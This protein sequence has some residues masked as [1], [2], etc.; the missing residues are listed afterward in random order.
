MDRIDEHWYTPDGALNIEKNYARL[1]EAPYDIENV[2]LGNE[3]W[4]G[5]REGRALLAFLCHYHISG[6]KIPCMEQMINELPRRGNEYMFFGDV[7]EKG[8]ANEQ[9]LSG[10]SWYLR[11]LAD[12]VKTFDDPTAL[13]ALKSTFEHLYLPALPLYDDYPLQR[14]SVGGDVDGNI[15]GSGHGWALSTDVG[16]A[17]MCVDG[18]AHYYAVTEDPHAHMF[19]EKVIDVFLNA[20][21]VARGFQT[22]TSLTCLRGMLSFYKTTGSEKYL[23]EVMREFARYQQYGMTLTYKN[24]NWFGRK[25]SWTEPCAVVDSLLLATELYRITGE[26]RY[27]ILARRIWANGLQFCQRDNGGA[28]TD[29]CVTPEDPVLKNR[30][31]EAYKCCTMRYAEGLRC[32]HENKDIFKY[33]P[34]A[35]VIVEKDGRRYSDDRLI[36]R[37]NGEIRPIFS[38]N[39]VPKEKLGELRLEVLF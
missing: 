10:H 25:D 9:Q 31:Y 11:G 20:D 5:D 21:M 36:V 37:V 15:C 23:R 22:H 13:R 28:G 12:Y 29:V 27:R 19:L 30:G 34:F 3:G 18:V 26:D 16:C 8:T 17:F 14:S 6:R 2:F 35:P 39:T 33:E 24:F 32:Y 1:N 4:P 7:P 38:C